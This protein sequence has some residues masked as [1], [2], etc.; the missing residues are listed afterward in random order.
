VRMRLQGTKSLNGDETASGKG[1]GGTKKDWADEDENAGEVS[2][3]PSKCNHKTL[4]SVDK[5]CVSYHLV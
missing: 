1:K 4:L 5:V 3:G 2:T